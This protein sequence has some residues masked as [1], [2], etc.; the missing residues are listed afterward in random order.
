MRYVH[1]V[2]ADGIA[3]AMP[4]RFV[5]AAAYRAM[6]YTGGIATQIWRSHFAARLL[7][8]IDGAFI[9]RS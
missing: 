5:E 1:V 9:P 8:Q 6:D 2:S 7:L 3:V 4:V